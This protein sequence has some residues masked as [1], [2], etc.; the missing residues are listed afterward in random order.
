M[1]YDTLII[2]G[3]QSGLATAYFLRRTTLNYLILDAQPQ[4]G[5]AWQHAWDSLHVILTTRRQFAPRLADACFRRRLS[6]QK[7]G[8]SL[9]EGL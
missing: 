1:V 3:G 5:G 4:T 6:Y 9:L 8:A 7:G 2:G